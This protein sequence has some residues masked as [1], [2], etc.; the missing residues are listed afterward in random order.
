MTLQRLRRCQEKG[1]NQAGGRKRRAAIKSRSRP[2]LIEVVTRAAAYQFCIAMR[3]ALQST[4]VALATAMAS[5]AT[6]SASPRRP[7]A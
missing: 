2:V 3:V 5:Q 1:G 6:L 7:S 4:P